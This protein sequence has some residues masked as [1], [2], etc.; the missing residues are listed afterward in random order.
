MACVSQF[1]LWLLFLLSEVRG[2]AAPGSC[3]RSSGLAPQGR[4]LWAAGGSSGM[5]LVLAE[6]RRHRAGRGRF[7]GAPSV[8]QSSRGSSS[9][10]IRIFFFLKYLS[11]QTTVKLGACLIIGTFVMKATLRLAGTF[12]SCK[13]HGKLGPE[14]Q[15]EG[16]TQGHPAREINTLTKARGQAGSGARGAAARACSTLDAQPRGCGAAGGAGWAGFAG[17]PCPLECEEQ[18][19]STTGLRGPGPFP[20]LSYCGCRWW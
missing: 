14:Q 15:T 11:P 19:T 3:P 2:S 6:L 8:T 20:G 4:E 9:G 12:S 1:F 17:V 13:V 16:G 10:V 18:L 5:G 7:P